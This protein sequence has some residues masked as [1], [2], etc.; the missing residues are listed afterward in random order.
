MA[1]VKRVRLERLA[2]SQI[3]IGKS[4]IHWCC[5]RRMTKV[6]GLDLWGNYVVFYLCEKDKK[7]EIP[8]YAQLLGFNSE[9]YYY[10]A[11]IKE[12]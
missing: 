8:Y 6:K 12:E 7:I 10:G 2:S 3:K 11:E 9:S 1:K 5:G 4:L